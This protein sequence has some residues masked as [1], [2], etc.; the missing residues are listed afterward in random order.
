VHLP[1]LVREIP[2]YELLDSHGIELVHEA[3][4]TIVEEFG[5][6]FDDDE[7]IALWRHA[8]ADIKGKKVHI[9]RDL[10][11]SLVAQAPSSFTLHARN[12]ERTVTIG[13]RHM[14]FGPN[15]ATF[16]RDLNGERR[17]PVRADLPMIV[18][19]IHCVPSIHVTT[20]WPA[21][22]LSDVPVPVRH[23]QQIYCPFR[24][25]DKPIGANSYTPEVAEDA[26]HMCRLVFGE[27]FMD[28]NTVVTTLANC[29][30]PL[31][32][33]RSMLDGLKI[34]A[35]AGQA[36]VCSPFVTYGASTPPHVLGAVAQVV[37][38]TLSAV[39]LVQLIRP[40]TPALFA[41]APMG[42]SMNS[43]AP[44]WGVPEV[45]HMLFLS[46]QMAR[47]YDLPWRAVGPVSG[48]KVCDFSAGQDMA[49]RAEQAVLAGCNWITHCT[50]SL[51]GAMQMDLA[52][53]VLAGEMMEANFVL[54][55]G[56]NR[57]DLP[58]VLQMIDGLGDE[59]HFLGA[60]YTRENLPF[61]P[62]LQDNE[63]HD[64]WALNGSQDAAARGRV[65]AA[66]LL[67][68]YDDAPPTLDPAI[69]DELKAFIRGREKQHG[70]DGV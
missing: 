53:L 18:K 55:R 7:S 68:R 22:D 33:D 69:D 36:V 24:Y 20:G 49:L 4:M 10:L 15:G 12:P 28:S 50:G 44:T 2:T 6:T 43:G 42:V 23:L 58:D 62:S 31:K 14:I 25:S 26:L 16:I 63:I 8:G 61:L 3:A 11:L 32:W 57:S 60:D 30:S 39:A 48:S 56:P 54:A 9:S 65:A 66:R 38:E 21:I 40:G 51:E 17:R 59:S 70:Y 1:T 35:K 67:E 19:L 47:Y 64:T 13:G 34:F 45:A 5:V 37:A 29:N 52:S 41:N 27:A 46:G